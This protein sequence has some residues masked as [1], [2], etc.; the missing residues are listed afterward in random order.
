M[1]RVSGKV[2]PVEDGGEP[3]QR[4]RARTAK[5]TADSSAAAAAED[6]AAAAWVRTSVKSRDVLVREY[7]MLLL[8][9]RKNLRFKEY[10]TQCT[11]EEKIADV[12]FDL[13]ETDDERKGKLRVLHRYNDMLDRQVHASPPFAST[14]TASPSFA[15]IAEVMGGLRGGDPSPFASSLSGDLRD[16]GGLG[17]RDCWTWRQSYYHTIVLYYYNTGR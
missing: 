9:E 5:P 1:R 4:K 13:S 2:A 7:I 10:L 12:T 17:A 14:R 8:L 3:A 16:L 6:A 11:L 15:S